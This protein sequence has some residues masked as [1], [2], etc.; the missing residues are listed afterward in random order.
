VADDV[1]TQEAVAELE[2]S[3]YGYMLARRSSG[4][5]VFVN[6]SRGYRYYVEQTV[7]QAVAGP[8]N[9]QVH[10]FH[11]M[12]SFTCCCCHAATLS[13]IALQLGDKK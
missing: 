11:L 3:T 12:S 7:V 1:C 13:V 9:I 5:A 8:S 2:L 10:C 6:E 4:R